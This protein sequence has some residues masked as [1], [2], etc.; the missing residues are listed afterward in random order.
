MPSFSFLLLFLLLLLLLLLLEFVCASVCVE[1]GE[2]FRCDE[3]HR[4]LIRKLLHVGTV[5]WGGNLHKASNCYYSME[6]SHCHVLTCG[7]E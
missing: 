4:P 2:H 6:A 3:S 7:W 5:G 1:Y